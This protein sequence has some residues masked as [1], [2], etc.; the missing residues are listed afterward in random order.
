MGI[1]S[2]LIEYCKVNKFPIDD[3]TNQDFKKVEKSLEYNS[4]MLNK[5]LNEIKMEII[6]GIKK[7]I[8]I[9]KHREF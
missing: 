1:D 3:M 8:K 4:Y 9:F 7:I 5:N 2:D 6:K